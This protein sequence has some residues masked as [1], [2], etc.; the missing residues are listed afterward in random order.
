MQRLRGQGGA[1]LS[2]FQSVSTRREGE[3]C[4]NL[5]M[6]RSS[7]RTGFRDHALQHTILCLM[8]REEFNS[9]LLNYYGISI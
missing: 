2:T 1:I 4:P 5:V 6:R 9:Y 8:N 3:H 7:S